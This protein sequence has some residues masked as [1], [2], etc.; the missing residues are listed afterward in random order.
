M[1]SFSRQTIF[2]NLGELDDGG[3]NNLYINSS[4]WAWG[5]LAVVATE[6]NANPLALIN[7]HPLAHRTCGQS[8]I[9]IALLDSSVAAGLARLTGESI[10]RA[11]GSA[12]RSPSCGPACEHAPR[13]GGACARCWGAGLTRAT[14]SPITHDRTV[15]AGPIKQGAHIVLEI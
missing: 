7:L 14:S 15:A 4:G 10:R 6:V 2:I 13:S 9:V 3:K 8:E 1:R 11:V 12:S 5:G